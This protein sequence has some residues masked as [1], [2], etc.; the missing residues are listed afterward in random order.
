MME[1]FK[2]R[3][4]ADK[5][6]RAQI[7]PLLALNGREIAESGKTEIP[8]E[9]NMPVLPVEQIKTVCSVEPAAREGGPAFEYEYEFDK[10]ERDRA[11]RAL[12]GEML[13]MML[14]SDMDMDEF[15]EKVK[16]KL[17]Y[18]G[19]LAYR[20]KDF[21]PR[22]AETTVRMTLNISGNKINEYELKR[23]T[24]VETLPTRRRPGRIS[25]KIRPARKPQGFA[26]A[27]ARPIACSIARARSAQR[28]SEPAPAND[29]S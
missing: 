14:D 28:L 12:V 1:K 16:L 8:M 10:E 19:A 4:F 21:V 15:I 13:K 11:S 9:I 6:L 17:D 22:E 3:S 18:E 5:A 7:E 26:R 25:G 27:E 20:E 24:L 29:C 23:Y 2:E